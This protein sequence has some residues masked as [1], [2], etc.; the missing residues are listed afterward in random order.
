MSKTI[1]TPDGKDANTVSNASMTIFGIKIDPV[2]AYPNEDGQVELDFKLELSDA[3]MSD[4]EIEFFED[5]CRGIIRAM[6][7][8]LKRTQIADLQKMR[9]DF[10]KDGKI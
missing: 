3:L 10:V 4:E 2:T 1:V 5:A 6:L 7:P 9:L 8:I